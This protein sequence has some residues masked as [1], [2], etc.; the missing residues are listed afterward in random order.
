LTKQVGIGNAKLSLEDRAAVVALYR[1]GWDITQL[2]RRY[3]VSPQAIRSLLKRRGVKT[4]PRHPTHGRDRL[5]RYVGEPREPEL[6]IAARNEYGVIVTVREQRSRE[7][8]SLHEP[9]KRIEALRAVCARIDRLPGE[10]KIVCYSTPEMIEGDLRGP[11]LKRH[12]GGKG[13]YL[14]NPEALALARIRRLDLLDPALAE[15]RRSK[16]KGWDG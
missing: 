12:P 5:G 8:R 15:R 16:P 6:S 13:S 7:L 1:D 11:R 3:G 14:E 2:S 4:R 9:G 10:W